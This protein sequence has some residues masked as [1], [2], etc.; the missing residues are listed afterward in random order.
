MNSRDAIKLNLDMSDMIV[1]MY[2]GDLDDGDLLVRP[3]PGT[4]H[5]AWQLG[6]L[7]A[8]ENHFIE[9]I[10]P[11]S[12][13]ALPAGFA[14]RHTPA[15]SRLDSASAFLTKAEYLKLYAEQRA[16]TLAT[17]AKQSDA[18]LDKAPPEKFKEYTKSVGDCFSLQGTHTMMHAGQ[19]AIIRRKLGRKPIF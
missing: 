2:L 17:L 10:V 9:E 18:D 8:S 7:I 6:H 14:D 5:I 16:A 1:N 13:P 15:T 3:I 11:G 19:W 12:M 4:N